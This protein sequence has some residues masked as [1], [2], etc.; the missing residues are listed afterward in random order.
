LQG[1]FKYGDDEPI[2]LFVNCN[3]PDNY[4]DTNLKCRINIFDE[5][6]EQK[7]DLKESTII[8]DELNTYI[9][10]YNSITRS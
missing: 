2:I 10:I 5:F 3:T 6:L 7:T 1:V 4:K 8:P 9:N